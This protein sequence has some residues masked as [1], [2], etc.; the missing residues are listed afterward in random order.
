[1]REFAVRLDGCDGLKEVIKCENVWKI[2][3][4]GTPAEVQALRGVDIKIKEGDFA[5]IMGSSG[6]G[7]STLLNC[8][9]LLDV[10][11]RGK[12][13]IDERDVSKLSE[14]ERVKIRRDKIGFVFQFFNLIPG[15]TAMKNVELPM[16]FKGMDDASRRKRAK[17][18]LEM[19]NLGERA[20]SL[21]SKLSGGE[22]QRVAIARALANDPVV[23]FADEPTG[24]LDSKTGKSIIQIFKR[25]NEDNKTIVVIT[26]DMSIGKETDKIYKM[27]DGIIC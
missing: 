18:L 22:S 15:L 21:P 3:N 26:H 20:N 4:Q 11:T 12:I 8:I 25:L 27:S 23:I 19:V 5:S 24:N 6:S 7:K 9:G 10:P 1:L 16:I 13:L 14:D 17:E 2:F